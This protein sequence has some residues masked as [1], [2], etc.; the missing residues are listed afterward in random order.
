MHRNPWLS[1]LSRSPVTPTTRPCSTSTSMPQSVGGQF[2]GHMVRITRRADMIASIYYGTRE[3]RRGHRAAGHPSPPRAPPPPPAVSQLS[4]PTQHPPL[5][6][7]P[8]EVTLPRPAHQ[9]SL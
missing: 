8:P 2:I 7:D 5:S 6:P 3:R 9:L 4:R 1:G